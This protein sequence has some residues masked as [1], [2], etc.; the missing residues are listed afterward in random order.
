MVLKGLYLSIP[1][2]FRVNTFLKYGVNMGRFES[3]LQRSSVPFSM[4]DSLDQ[5]PQWIALYQYRNNINDK[6]YI[7]KW[8]L[9]KE[10]N[11]PSS[12]IEL[13]SDINQSNIQIFHPLMANRESGLLIFD[14]DFQQQLNKTGDSES[15]I[16]ILDIHQLMQSME[17]VVNQ[18]AELNSNQPLDNLSVIH[19]AELPS[20]AQVCLYRG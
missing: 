4:I 1:T 12:S 16:V 5:F 8:P 9:L 2:L 19:P 6:I 13:S 14:Y 10:L 7:H 3:I 15:I 18:I 17:F 20:G 11:W